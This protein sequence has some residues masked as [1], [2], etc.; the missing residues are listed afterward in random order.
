M[1][2]KVREYVVGG[3]ALCLVV[4]GILFASYLD[5]TRTI[6]AEVAYIHNGVITFVDTTGE[7]WEYEEDEKTAD[8]FKGDE[9]KLTFNMMCTTH[10]IYDDEIINIKKIN[11]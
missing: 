10:F 6:N 8:I 5:S 7:K 2:K 9:V 3:F 11:K 1:N 4:V